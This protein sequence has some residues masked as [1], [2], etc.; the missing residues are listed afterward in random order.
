V[1]EGIQVEIG[2]KG[3]E[4]A[5]L[6]KAAARGEPA[7]AQAYT[8][9]QEASDE[10]QQF[11]V[12]LCPGEGSSQDGMVDGVEEILDIGLEDARAAV[13]AMQK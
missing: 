8:R 4:G 1:V 7:A 10:V 9:R 6:A 11:G 13:A 12:D 3:R 2:Q 5:A